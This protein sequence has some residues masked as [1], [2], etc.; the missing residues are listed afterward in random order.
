[1][2]RLVFCFDGTW[3]TLEAGRVT[4][5]GIVAQ[6]VASTS[7]DG[8]KQVV[9]Y[10]EGVGNARYGAGW[11]TRTI[12]KV[13]GGAFGHGLLANLVEAY[14][15]L[16][17][18]Y[19]PGDEVIV[20]GFSRGAF[21]A[22]SFVGLLRASGVP[23]RSRVE[24]VPDAIENYRTLD[25]RKEGDE[26]K[27]R[28]FRYEHGPAVY[29]DDD[30]QAWRASNFPDYDPD[31]AARLQVRYLGVWDTVGALGVPN[32]LPGLAAIF[33]TKYAFHD[34]SLDP[35]VTAAR[36]AVAIDER[37][38]TFEPSLWDNVGEMNAR[39]GSDSDRYQQLWFPGTHGSVGGGGRVR[40]LSDGAL[41]WVLRGAQEEG[42]AI[43]R[44]GAA[45]LY[46]LRPRLAAPLENVDPDA[47]R[48]FIGWVVDLLPKRD[49]T[50]GPNSL[51]EVSDAARY[52]WAASPD[53]LPEKKAYRPVTLAA[54]SGPLDAFAASEAARTDREIEDEA[55]EVYIVRRGDSLSGICAERYGKASLWP[56]LFEI[57]KPAVM[58]PDE[59]YVGQELRV[60]SEEV[61]REVAD[62]LKQASAS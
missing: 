56:A 16:I 33:N 1:M 11:I 6:S 7:P 3:N 14:E 57:N 53:L 2:K 29:V 43:D 45:E 61:I 41:A 36:H 50:P 62:R 22:R 17:F 28:A 10:D 40:G 42:L 51:E 52:R 39:C 60:P 19:E 20:F 13:F 34:C 27:L 24:R 4:N 47:K 32:Q 55:A 26:A 31:G 21:S 38:R 35:F 30:E 58:N 18:N 8:T 59:I 25:P 48:T 9:Y 37:K 15:F 49:R 44:D 23:R 12:E 5:V 54:L 46:A